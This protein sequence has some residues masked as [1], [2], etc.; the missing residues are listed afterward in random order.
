MHT[1]EILNQ[2]ADAVRDRASARGK[3]QERSMARCVNAFNALTGN[4]L[5]E[6]DG[7]VFMVVLKMA[8]ATSTP[9]GLPDD[10]VDAAAYCGL[11]GEAATERT[12]EEV[13][14]V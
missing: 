11:A 1:L 7:W 4:N 9:T 14:R 6:R 2:A 10:Y 5:S 13:S 3:S 12:Y 8:R